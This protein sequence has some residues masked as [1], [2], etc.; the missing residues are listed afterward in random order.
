MLSIGLCDQI[1]KVPNNT[2][3]NERRYHSVNVI[4]LSLS[5]KQSHKAATNVTILIRLNLNDLT[6]LRITN[7]CHIKQYIFYS[8]F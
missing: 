5:Q 8:T 4:I 7:M 3:I 1:S 2:I 6:N